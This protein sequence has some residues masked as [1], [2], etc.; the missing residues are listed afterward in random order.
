MILPRSGAGLPAWRR[1]VATWLMGALRL[2]IA[3]LGAHTPLYALTGGAVSAALPAFV[4]WAAAGAIVVGA[5][6]FAWS[7]TVLIGFV[8]LALGLATYMYAWEKIGF[9]RDPLVLRTVMIMLVLTAGE[10]LVRRVQ[11]KVYA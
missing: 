1:Q 9:E 8:V 5:L 10:M 6:L 3:W 2:G 7:R 11:K 4:R